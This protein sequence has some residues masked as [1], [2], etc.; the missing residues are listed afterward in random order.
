MSGA[1][2]GP[3]RARAHQAAIVGL[4]SL[5]LVAVWPFFDVR[6]LVATFY[7]YDDNFYYFQVARNLG[8]GGGFTFDGVH[9][10]NGFH[11]LWAIVLAPLFAAL[12]GDEAPLR[13]VAVLEA[14]LVILSA[15]ILLRVLGSRLGSR[16]GLTAALALVAQP[17][18]LK[19][20]RAGMESSLFLFLLVAT[21]ARWLALR[22]DRGASPGA[23][24]GLG[25]LCGLAFLSRLEAA[26]LLPM[27]LL[28]GWRRFREQPR[29]ALALSLPVIGCATLYFLSNRFFFGVWIP[30]SALV[31]AHWVRERSA[32]FLRGLNPFPEG[33][34]LLRASMERLDR[35]WW[36]S[37]VQA[38]AVAWCLVAAALALAWGHRRSLIVAFR[39]AGA[40][41]PVLSALLVL[42]I[43]AWA[44]GT[45]EPWQRVPVLLAAAVALA[46]VLHRRPRLTRLALVACVTATAAR[47]P[48]SIWHAQRCPGNA[49]QAAVLHVLAAADWLGH[50]TGPEERVGSWS[51]AG[52]LAYF[53]HRPVVSLDGLVNDVTFFRTV[54]QERRL[55]EYLRRERISLLAEPACGPTPAIA[56]T[57]AR[58]LWTGQ[59]AWP[60]GTGAEI[61]RHRFDLLVSWH[62]AKSP[63]GCP[64]FAIW[65]VRW[66]DPW[67]ASRADSDWPPRA[68]PSPPPAA[69]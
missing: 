60:A 12:P 4:F 13:A 36:L 38:D 21:W 28:L 26:V 53:S 45:L 54:V 32:G 23:W 33:P 35:P 20:V 64:G 16:V 63:D 1:R 19:V 39:R 51:S 55:E 15:L 40:A 3:G 57:I 69:R 48:L 56:D 62:D 8:A 43:H 58:V 49:T 27:L 68:P 34:W 44:V 7:A 65:R 24:A 30:I 10:T 14:I 2:S 67:H 61:L 18:S 25:A 17:G 6:T 52:M 29:S 66:R 42:S 9:R 22:R 31:K 37:W 50:Q 46:L 41:F 59:G 47:V 5:A 11:P